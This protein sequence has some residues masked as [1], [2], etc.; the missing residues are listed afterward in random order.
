M[1]R[2][3]AASSW[4]AVLALVSGC[5][6]GP[7]FHVPAAPDVSGY[8][9]E[10][11]APATVAA[12]V[13]GGAAQRFVPGGEIPGQWWA[14]FHSQP[15]NDLIVAALKANSDLQAAQAALLV[16]Q[17]NV[18]AQQG[19]YLPAIAGN[20]TPSRNKTATGALSPASASGN[21]Y[22]SLYTAEVSVSYTPDVFGL[23]RRT[24]ESLEAQAQAQR[25]ALE[26]T[27]LT[28]TSNVVAAA[29]Q[30]ASL[31]GQIAATQDI[32]DSE[33]QLLD[34]LRRQNELGQIAEA[35]VVAQEAALAQAQAALPPLMKQ[36][37]QQRDLLTALAG[38][39]PSEEVA[40]KFEL[41]SLQLPQDLP[42]SLPSKLVEQRPDIRAA[43]E[44]LHSASALV[45]VAL[46]NMLP[47][48]TL[49]AVDGGAANTLD[50][51]FTPGTGFWS[52]A[53][54]L[55]QPLFEGGTLLAR[56]RAAAAAY[57]EAAAQY[58]S[59][60]ITAFQNVADTLRALQHDAEALRAAVAAESAASESLAITRR[61]L[62]LGNISYP[63]LLA[64]QQ[65]YQQAVI[66]RVQAQA[67]RYAD[68]AALFQ[69]LGGGW[70]NRKDVAEATGV[71]KQATP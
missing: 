18:R 65:T 57:D 36:L 26:A 14:L 1:Q 66:N 24:V 13:T 69:A 60:V 54:S 42:V 61:Q 6:V 32:V 40:E 20:F 23:N 45:G 71:E 51:L 49:S 19:F 52:L 53:G 47:N 16:A 12:E 3:L 15:L 35:D 50:R 7:D 21:P 68:T 37:A 33:S 64:A 41:S 46:A 34:I 22:Y 28:L 48:I 31:R 43:E 17:E 56:K 70:W 2:F 44:Q 59:T 30:E 38:R 4:L 8:T 27:Y 39:F 5:A 11:L 62:E 29:V 67:G 9:P 25:F 10:K 63:A 55:T 58:R